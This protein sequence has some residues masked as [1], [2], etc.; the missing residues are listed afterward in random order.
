MNYHLINLLLSSGGETLDTAAA[1][2]EHLL[3][4][5]IVETGV[6]GC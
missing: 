4:R 5:T 3:A 2:S 1:R 6:F